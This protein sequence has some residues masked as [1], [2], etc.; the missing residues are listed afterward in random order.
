MIA[1]SKP[2]ERLL[3]SPWMLLL[4]AVN[5]LI[6][7]GAMPLFDLDEGAFSSATM[8][9]LQRGD[10]ITTYM[11]G[12]LRFDKPI[13]IYW[14]QALSVSGL[15]LNEFALRLPSALCAIAW[16]W[17]VFR[18]VRTYLD[19]SRAVAAALMLAMS[20][21]VS[22]I[23]RAATADALLN[24]WLCLAICDAYRLLNTPTPGKFIAN[25]LVLRAYLWVGL[26]VLAKGPVAILVPVAVACLYAL[27]ARRWQHLL[28]LLFNPL[29][30]LICLGVFMPWYIAEY[31]A[32]GQLFIDGFLF[33]H[34]L[35]RFNDTME[36]H[37]GHL[38]YYLP[39][40]L[41]VF[42]PVCGL[43]LQLVLKLRRFMGD[44][45]SRF[46]WIWFGFVLVFFSFS[47]TQLPHYLLY[48]ATPVFILIAKY[49]EQLSG[50][51]WLIV[52]PLMLL[53][54]FAAL[55]E[56]AKQLIA[57]G[58]K[59]EVAAMLSHGMGYLDGTYRALVL[60][61]MA[62]IL[63]IGLSRLS[64]ASRQLLVA[65][66]FGLTFGNLLLPTYGKI[67]QLPV[68]EAVAVA[69]TLDKTIVMD[70]HDM[71]S[72]SVYL[73]RV[74]PIRPP[75]AGE[76]VFTGLDQRKH[77]PGATEVFNQGGVLLLQMPDAIQEPRP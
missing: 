71:P 31:R 9:M 68:Q 40:S 56:I 67:Q 18:F 11:G 14:L 15:G 21:V 19:P 52:P 33:K 8:E 12:E 74:V 53:G 70:H 25:P 49:R 22:V 61:A 3:S 26:G 39:V 10:Y 27:S 75:H 37:G 1:Q 60:L 76:V 65:L 46:C 36:G 35:S 30:W 51:W 73:G 16:C 24:L 57:E 28:R 34:N 62:L 64:V 32:Q 48:G 7:L 2:W 13:F 66:V 4:I 55:P 63:V 45:L 72:F 44:D 77:F 5:F 42:M 58:K 54:L 6:G 47:N 50:R 17:V 43:F 29:G 38:Y 41:L 23:G 59:E 69:K 20:L